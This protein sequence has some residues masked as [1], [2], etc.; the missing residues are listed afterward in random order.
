MD[1]PVGAQKAAAKEVQPRIEQP[2]RRHD[3]STRSNKKR[4]GK[5]KNQQIN[6]CCSPNILHEQMVYFFFIFLLDN[7]RLIM[8]IPVPGFRVFDTENKTI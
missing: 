1:N 5:Q 4:D 2:D 8:F 6:N 7:W 3:G